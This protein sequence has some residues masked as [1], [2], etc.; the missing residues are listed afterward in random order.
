MNEKKIWELLNVLEATS[1]AQVYVCD[2]AESVTVSSGSLH[3][4]RLPHVP[5]ADELQEQRTFIFM[6]SSG[7]DICPGH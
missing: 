7:Q 6:D 2:L 5:P 1:P 4:S 3:N